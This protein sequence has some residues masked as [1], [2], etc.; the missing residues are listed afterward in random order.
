MIKSTLE[1]KLNSSEE[2]LNTVEKTFI[3]RKVSR[4]ELIHWVESVRISSKICFLEDPPNSKFTRSQL[5]QF[6]KA[7]RASQKELQ[8]A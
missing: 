5:K 7:V 3:G 1:E 6:Y 8:E 2:I 4:G